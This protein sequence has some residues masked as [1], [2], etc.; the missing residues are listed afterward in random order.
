MSSPYKYKR[1]LND[2]KLGSFSYCCASFPGLL[3]TT[4]GSSRLWSGTASLTIIE[5]TYVFDQL[6]LLPNGGKYSLPMS[7]RNL[8]GNEIGLDSDTHNQWR[9][10]PGILRLPIRCIFLQNVIVKNWH[11][12]VASP[13]GHDVWCTSTKWFVLTDSRSFDGHG[14]L[15]VSE[16]CTTSLYVAEG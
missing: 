8:Y 1:L 2:L 13:N 12:V 3:T 16:D 10:R 4:S 14:F 11:R 9:R 15:Q 6:R 7:N 5:P